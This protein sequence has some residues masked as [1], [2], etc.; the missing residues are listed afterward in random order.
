MEPRLSVPA[1]ISC[2]D[3]FP[4]QQ[5]PWGEELFPRKTSPACAPG[6]PFLIGEDQFKATG[7]R[8]STGYYPQVPLVVI[9][10]RAWLDFAFTGGVREPNVRVHARGAPL[11][12]VG[13]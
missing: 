9:L 12:V 11:A 2:P 4:L 10:H 1:R 7:L 8:C 13:D 3:R 6:A 5:L